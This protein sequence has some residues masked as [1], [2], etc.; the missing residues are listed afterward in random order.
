MTSVNIALIV[1]GLVIAAINGFAG[2]FVAAQIARV[3]ARAFSRV[4]PARAVAAAAIVVA[5][6]TVLAVSLGGGHEVTC[7]PHVDASSHTTT[8]C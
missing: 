5:A 4:R 7:H 3:F 6:V 2:S 1:T 8:S